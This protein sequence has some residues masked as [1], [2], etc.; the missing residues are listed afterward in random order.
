M[1]RTVPS[2]IPAR[3]SSAGPRQVSLIDEGVRIKATAQLGDGPI[4]RLA[5][6]FVDPEMTSS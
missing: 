1:V 2:M 4:A 5:N 3:A 6:P